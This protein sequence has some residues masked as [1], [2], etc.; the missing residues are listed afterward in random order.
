MDYCNSLLFGIKDY[1]L[2][3]LQSIQNAAAR[4]IHNS[5]K[6]DHITPI[7]K[8]LH[9]LKIKERIDFKILVIT[10][11][12]VHR[13]E[14]KYLHDLLVTRH[15]NIKNLRSNEKN[16]LFTP[17]WKLK[18]CGYRRFS[19]AAPNLWNSVP[20]KLRDCT[21]FKMFKKLLK[22]HLFKKSHSVWNFK[23]S[24]NIIYCVLHLFNS[25]N[26]YWFFSLIKAFAKFLILHW[27]LKALCGIFI[28]SI[29]NVNVLNI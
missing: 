15:N 27:L 26:I 22:T 8:N 14:P 19:V 1:Q 17:K 23:I 28:M 21:D 6:Y 2:K 29:S 7:L 24:F 9:W 18:S 10:F 11:K 16:Y 4:L 25:I 20:Q 3:K 12:A 5:S 13:K